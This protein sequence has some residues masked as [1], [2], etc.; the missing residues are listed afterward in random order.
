MKKSI[1]LL[2]FASLAF[3]AI[4]QTDDRSYLIKESHRLYA[5]GKYGTAL[6]LIEDIDT[7]GLEATTKQELELTGGFYV[8]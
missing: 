6:T 4:G 1:F 2:M 5:E 3:T 7:D 8:I